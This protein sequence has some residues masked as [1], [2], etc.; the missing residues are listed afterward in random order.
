MSCHVMSCHVG[1][2]SQPKSY[3]TWPNKL[4]LRIMVVEMWYG[5]L[6]SGED[7]VP[8][9]GIFKTVAM[10]V[11]FCLEVWLFDRDCR[12]GREDK[13]VWHVNVT[14]CI[15]TLALN[16]GVVMDIDLTSLWGKCWMLHV[17]D[18]STISSSS[19]SS[20]SSEVFESKVDEW[21]V[22]TGIMLSRK[23]K[24]YPAATSE[25]NTTTGVDL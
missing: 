2:V 8:L 13:N 7:S 24:L 18:V 17:W 21:I 19:S 16:Q 5:W 12:C 6:Y 11:V 15:A 20:S 3:S 14:H 22:S 10:Q 9:V 1:N 23:R 4:D 25:E